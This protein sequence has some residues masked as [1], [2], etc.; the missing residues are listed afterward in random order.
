MPDPQNQA[1]PPPPGFTPVQGAVPSPPPGFQPVQN[2]NN[3]SPEEVAARHARSVADARARG[4]RTDLP[5][6]NEPV[7]AMATGIGK[8]AVSTV[9]GLANLENKILP[10]AIQLPTEQHQI[11]TTLPAQSLSDVVAGK[12]SL[13]DQALTAAKDV[14]TPHG[15]GETIGGLGENMV[16]W[17]TGEAGVKLGLEGLKGI[18]GITKTPEAV[19]ALLEK[20]PKTAKIF[21]SAAKGATIGGTQ[22]AV[23]ESAT[24][25]QGAEAGLKEGAAGGAAGSVAAEVVPMVAKPL[26]KAF[27]IGTTSEEDISKAAQFAKN[28]LNALKDW[29]KAQGPIAEAFEAT[30]EPK[31][32]AEGVEKIKDVRSSK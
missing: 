17:L 14:D 20:Y 25:G 21:A 29:A 7:E 13:R 6:S 12:P 1:P 10:S 31:T 24:G 8:E 15:A 28:N 22:G 11:E 30:G 32:L 23:K 27:G 4:L 19:L 3:Q 9:S 16:E 2:V 5:A 26:G 18:I